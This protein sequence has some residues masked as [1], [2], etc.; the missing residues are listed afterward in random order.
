[1]E[2]KKQKEEDKIQRQLAFNKDETATEVQMILTACLLLVIDVLEV[3]IFDFTHCMFAGD[4][5]QRASG[6]PGRRGE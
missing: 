3:W 1:M 2:V 4:D 5:L 6:R